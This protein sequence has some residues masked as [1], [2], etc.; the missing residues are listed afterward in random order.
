MLFSCRSVVQ[1]WPMPS[2]SKST[3]DGTKTILVL[4]VH[5]PAL[6]LQPSGMQIIHPVVVAVFPAL[7]VKS[8]ATTRVTSVTTNRFEALIV[9]SSLGK[10]QPVKD[11][12]AL[13]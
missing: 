5:S 13:C 4:T 6:K 1:Q 8:A 2:P 12:P 10:W 7:M 3:Q 11:Y 9:Q